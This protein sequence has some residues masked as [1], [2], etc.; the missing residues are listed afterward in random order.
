M[1]GSRTG[2]GARQRGGSGRGPAGTRASGCEG[3]RRLGRPSGSAARPRRWRLRW[4]A[5]STTAPA[6]ARRSRPL[7]RPIVGALNV[8]SVSS[9]A[10]V[11]FPLFAPAAPRGSVGD[12]T[13]R[14][15]NG[16][17][18][19]AAPE[20]FPGQLGLLGRWSG[21]AAHGGWVSWWRAGGDDGDLAAVVDV[22][23]RGADG[24]GPVDRGEAPP[25]IAQEPRGPGGG[26]AADAE[27]HDL[28]LVVDAV[29]GGGLGAGNPEGGEPAP[30]QHEPDRS[31]DGTGDAGD[32]AAVVDPSG[33]GARLAGH[34][35]RPE[36]PPLPHIAVEAA[37]GVLVLAHDL[38]AVVDV[39]RVGVAGAGDV[40]PDIAA[41]VQQEPA[42]GGVGGRDGVAVGAVD[43]HDL[44][45]VVDPLGLAAH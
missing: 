13:A 15:H 24:A 12:Q 22:E 26:G 4:P 43:A 41:A 21:H 11:G 25:G 1:A 45:T 44:A 35:D 16:E 39:K 29:G 27:A 36:P 40:E 42:A 8:M 31:L 23:G 33:V 9:S 14:P 32:L 20:P 7:T 37:V 19:G 28:A 34:V 17:W 18:P 2:L 10:R 6:T 5:V 3:R 38:A 30:V